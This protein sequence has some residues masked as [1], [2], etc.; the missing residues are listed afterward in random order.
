MVKE[1]KKGKADK[2]VVFKKKDGTGV[3]FTARFT[4]SFWT[5]CG[6]VGTHT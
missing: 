4:R 1:R 6:V 2:S 5:N 3:S